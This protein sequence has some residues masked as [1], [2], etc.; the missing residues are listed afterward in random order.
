MRKQYMD[1]STSAHI[2]AYQMQNLFKAA[3]GK[4]WCR[5]QLKH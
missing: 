2:T 4:A 5:A 1:F 3:L